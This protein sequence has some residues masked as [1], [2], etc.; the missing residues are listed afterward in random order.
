MKQIK[1]LYLYIGS[2]FLIVLISAYGFNNVTKNSTAALGEI[3]KNS[4]DFS[5]REK[6]LSLAIHVANKITKEVPNYILNF[7][8]KSLDKLNAS[9]KSAKLIYEDAIEKFYENQTL[10]DE[11]KSLKGKLNLT[12]KEASQNITNLSES[13]LKANEFIPEIKKNALEYNETTKLSLENWNQI[14]KEIE[15][16]LS[17]SKNANLELAKTNSTKNESSGLLTTG[18]ISILSILG[19]GILV[20]VLNTK[21]SRNE[22]IELLKTGTISSSGS[23]ELFQQLQFLED[24]L[25]EIGRAHV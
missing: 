5:E 4:K 10:S 21:N 16:N 19:F 18:S 11:E 20:I 13:V 3:L 24:H 25:K 22:L 1:F 15:S 9:T 7:D 6:N 17:K 2:I 8:P 14:L 23:N 12:Y